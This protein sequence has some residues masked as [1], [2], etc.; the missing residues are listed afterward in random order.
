MNIRFNLSRAAFM[1]LAVLA[2]PGASAARADNIDEELMR[3]A[4]AIMKDL[5]DKHYK[6]V[7]VLKFR[8]QKGEKESSFNVG[9]LNAN[10]AMRL[11]TAL[12]LVNSEKSPIGITRDASTV[13]ALKNK[14]A[15]YLTAADR[16]A[17]FENTFPLA[18]GKDKVSVDAFLTGQV[19][20]NASTRKTTVIIEVFDKQA[21]EL[22][23]VANFT[24][25]TDRSI[26]S[27]TSES[28]SLVMRDIARKRGEDLEDEA[29]R[30]AEARDKGKRVTPA[31]D[32][33]EGL[34]DVE[35]YYN[36]EKADVTPDRNDKGE[37]RVAEPREGQK[38]HFVL[39]NKTNEKLAVVLRINGLNTLSK[40]GPEKQVNQYTKWVLEPKKEY[41]IRGFYPEKG[42]VELFKVVP[43]SAL[44]DLHADKLGLIELDVFREAGPDVEEALKT[45]KLSLRGLSAA[46][47]SADTIDELKKKLRRASMD[48][49]KRPLIVGGDVENV[50]VKEV[51]FKHLVHTGAMTIRYFP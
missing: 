20:V 19:K 42:G 6:N 16:P 14:K 50:T 8:V 1:A 45:R 34:L 5:Q 47:R 35:I 25:P 44:G 43:P 3:R 10:M 28:F 29:A 18:W 27:D 36:G 40:E 26:L 13:V 15:N 2:A 11:E 48:A 4:T 37:K 51:E 31:E 41:A 12:V 33:I 49:G 39:R 32:T 7:G 22:R 23:E 9:M 30:D 38:V 17:M 21:P 24:V 46:D